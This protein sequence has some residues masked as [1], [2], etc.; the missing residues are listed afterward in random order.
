M[1]RYDTIIV[2]AGV[3]GA[4]AAYHLAKRGRRVLL[5]EQFAVGNERGSSHGHSRIIRLA[6]DA[7]DYV[8]LAQ[9]SFPLWRALEAESGAALL[10]QTGG[11]D[12]APPGTPTFEATRKSLTAVGVAF[13]ELDHAGLAE[14]FP[15]FHPPDETIG[16]YQLDAGI[17]NAN[18]CVATLA[19]QARKDGAALHE[20]EPA[21]RLMPAGSGVE[22]QTSAATYAADR[23]IVAAGSWTRPL[24]LQL[25]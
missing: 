3:M 13:E 8:R 21:R 4:A 7:P 10:L 25:G 2:G 19:A 1:E 11:L 14:R 16:I 5:L 20:G 24:L 23:L 12:F 22:V 9:A 15:Q 6:Y 17:L 18:A